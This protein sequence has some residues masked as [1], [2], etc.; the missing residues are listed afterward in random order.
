MHLLANYPFLRLYLLQAGERRALEA[1]WLG[2]ASSEQRRAALNEALQL[3][4]EHRV[5]AW[6]ADD[7]LLGHVPAADLEWAASVLMSSF[8]E[9][10]IKRMAVVEAVTPLS[11]R[12]IHDSMNQVMPTLPIALRRFTELIAARHWALQ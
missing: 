2:H 4:R 8:V 10:G 3:A 11:Q 9:C 7:R 12:L 6:V 1:E 5:G